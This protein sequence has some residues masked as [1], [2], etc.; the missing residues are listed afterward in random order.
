MQ[1]SYNFDQNKIIILN[2][3]ANIYFPC[4]NGNIQAASLVRLYVFLAISS[5]FV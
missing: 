1:G 3:T 4:K 5:T 2:I